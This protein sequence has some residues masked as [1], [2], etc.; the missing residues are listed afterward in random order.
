[1]TAKATSQTICTSLLGTALGVG[2]AAAAGQSPAAALPCFAALAGLHVW[3]G[4]RSAGAVPLAT[5]NPSRAAALAERHLAA[6]QRRQQQRQQQQQQGGA[7]TCTF[8]STSTSTSTSR[9]TCTLRACA[10]LPTPAQ[11]APH[12]PVLPA[13]GRW[14]AVGASLAALAARQPR[15][16]AALLPLYRAQRH[17]LI[18]VPGVNAGAD[19]YHVVLH[20]GATAADALLGV[21]QAAAWRAAE[22]KAEAAGGPGSRGGSGGG[23]GCDDAQVVEAAGAA[24]RRAQ[25]ELAPFLHAL[26]AAGWDAGRVVLEASRRRAAW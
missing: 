7:C 8:T 11:L 18:P 22:A 13:R 5:L 9:C 2:L 24:L 17:I 10:P 3:S 20:E 1:V 15:R 14:L 21:L 23:V 16:L 26:Q 12:D 6:Q 4:W 25:A 19:V